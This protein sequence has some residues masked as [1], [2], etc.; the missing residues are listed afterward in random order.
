[1]VQGDAAKAT[2][3]LRERPGRDALPHEGIA[4]VKQGILNA[5][6]QYPTGG[7]EAIETVLKILGGQQVEKT[8]VLGSRVFTSENVGQGGEALP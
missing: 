7:A 4:Y 2:S 1:M 3:G 8:I 5:T 6:F